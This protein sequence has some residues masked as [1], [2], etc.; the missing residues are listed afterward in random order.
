MSPPALII[1]APASG[2]GKTVMTLALLRRFRNDGA[3][4]SSFKVG[5]DYI[6]PAYHRAASGRACVNLDGWAMR[7]ATLA[8]LAVAA[9][10]GA[11]ITDIAL[12]N[13]SIRKSSTSWP[14]GNKA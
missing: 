11:L 12:S 5:P 6:D 13:S 10:D 2:A 14:L 8:R 1:A 3:R 9:G 4:V 7:P